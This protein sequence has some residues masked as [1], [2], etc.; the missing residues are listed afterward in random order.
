MAVNLFEG[1]VKNIWHGAALFAAGAAAGECALYGQ[2]GLSAIAVGAGNSIINQG[3]TNGWSNIDW[4]QVGISGTM[5]L[6]TSAIGGQIG[7]YFA[8]PLGVLTSNIPNTVLRNV[9]YYSLCNSSAGFI[10]GTGFS[11]INGNEGGIGGALKSGLE[12][13]GMGLVTGAISGFGSGIQEQRLQK[14]L[15]IQYDINK[16]Q[17]EDI[18][19]QVLT[20]PETPFGS[21]T[22]SVYIGR[23]ANGNVRYVGITERNPQLR[24]NEHLNSG[25]ERSNLRFDVVNG[26]GAL[27]RIQARIIEQ[28]LINIY[29][30]GKNGGQLYNKINSISP[31]NWYKYG[32]I[33]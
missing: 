2:V 28:R 17:P 23:D 1:N 6:I 21:G 16:I 5:S 25:A 32:I 24:F 8:K 19:R 26:T 3:F 31:D 27:S 11:L 4:G 30:L 13:A 7:G 14:T 29:G 10:L 18:A 9:A 15:S 20:S 33:Q 22:N 12:S